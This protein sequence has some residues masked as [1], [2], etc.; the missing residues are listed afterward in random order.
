MT[1]TQAPTPGPL[2]VGDRVVAIADLRKLPDGPVWVREGQEVVIVEEFGV[3]NCLAGVLTKDGNEGTWAKTCFRLAPTAPVENPDEPCA[4]ENAIDWPNESVDPIDERTGHPSSYT[5]PVEASGSERGGYVTAFYEIADMLG[6]GAQAASPAEVWSQ[7]MR[8]RLEAALRPQP[9][10]ETR[11]C[12]ACGAFKADRDASC[13]F[14]G[15]GPSAA[16]AVASCLTEREGA[17]R[18]A[19]D[20]LIDYLH[21][22]LGD[23]YDCKRVWSAWSYGT[24]GE[25]DF[26]PVSDRIDDIADAILALLSAR[27]LALGAQQGGHA[28]ALEPLRR[29][30]SDL[31][32]HIQAVQTAKKEGGSGNTITDCINALPAIVRALEAAEFEVEAAFEEYEDTTPA[33]AEAQDEGAAAQRDNEPLKTDDTGCVTKRFVVFNRPGMA[34]EKK[35]GW[36]KDEHLIGFLRE[37]ML[38]NCWTPGFRATVLG[39]TWNNDLWASSASEYL[40]AHDHAIG[41]RR[42]RKAWREAREKHERIYKSAPSMPLGQEIATYHVSTSTSPPAADDDTNA[43]REQFAEEIVKRQAAE[44]ER[45]DAHAE[46]AADED[47]VRADRYYEA[48]VQADLKIRS[49]PGTDQSD[50]EFIRAALKSEGK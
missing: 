39:L 29:S 35:G 34:P 23:T 49:L 40:S 42:A 27:P 7:K 9:S 16:D 22:E 30:I 50:V 33:R 4:P 1:A 21:Q 43:L 45:D 38:L 13:T 47:R 41:S 37:V 24:M 44:E 3:N 26:D 10:G 25:D 5:A 46:I 6:I 8:P 31:K 48:L 14:C 18:E 11:E 20:Q 17:D 19:R 12:K 36:L 15:L 32:T 28:D 2:S